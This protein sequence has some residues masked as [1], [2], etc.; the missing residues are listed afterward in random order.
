METITIDGMDE[1]DFRH[2]IEDMLRLD[3]VDEA[4]E[5]LRALLEPYVGGFLPSRFLDINS[6]SIEFAGWP[7]LARRLADYDR[8]SY[9]ISAI[10]IALADARTLGGPGP[11]G[12]R[13][14]PFIKTFYFSDDAYP[15]TD[16][17]RDDLLEGYTREGFGW[18]GDYQATDATLSIKGLDD[19]HGAIVELEDRLF[20]AANPPED[21]IRA[22][23]IG[24]CYL[25]VLIHQALREAIRKHGLPRPLCVLA[26][27]DGVYPFFDAPVAGSDECT[28][29]PSAEPSPGTSGEPDEDEVWPNELEG[30]RPVDE[31]R[32]PGPSLLTALHP[33]TKT[34]VLILDEAS[35]A[36]ALR[37]TELAETERMAVADELD[38]KGIFHGIPAAE[39]VFEEWP[40][41]EGQAPIAIEP[42]PEPEPEPAPIPQIPTAGRI[43]A[44]T[45]RAIRAR[46]HSAQVPVPPRPPHRIFFGWLRRVL[47]W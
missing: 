7:R 23:S 25:A 17:T 10:G 42:D 32:E 1:H 34:P 30:A 12:G 9:P 47:F 3:Q 18:Q 21:A 46:I 26:A 8:A 33:R 35:A 29:P 22:G 13:L 4:V 40:E 36:E 11:S 15:F 44:P 16:A 14:A 2:A 27:C 24:A 28:P 41:P 20:D 5:K 38:L 6:A 37:Y 45:G 31:E 43:V 39:L 19:L